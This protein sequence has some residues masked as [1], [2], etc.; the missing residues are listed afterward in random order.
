MTETV[1][2]VNIKYYYSIFGLYFESELELPM[3]NAISKPHSIDAIIQFGE[4]PEHLENPQDAR[5]IYEAKPNHFLMWFNFNPV[6]Y[7]VTNGNTI[8]IHTGGHQDWDFIRLFTLSPAMGA[9]LHQRRVIPLHASGFMIDG[10]AVLFSGQSGAGKSTTAAAFRDKGY[11]LVADDVSVIYNDENNQPI[12]EPG[13]PFVKLWRESFKLL[14]KEVPVN[15]R[16]REQVEK[17]Y[18][19]IDKLVEKALPI[20]RI[21]IL[22]KSSLID[23]PEIKTLSSID[24]VH[25]LRMGTYRYYY[26]IG[27]GGEPEF[28]KIA[29]NLGSQGI[30]KHLTRPMEYPVEDLV[31][32]VEEDLKNG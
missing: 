29:F 9:L 28:F 15:G 20:K 5:V 2:S 22:E 30:V 1:S 24:T 19:P 32:L 18:F 11:T 12:V 7:Y 16:I 14:D 23:T 10:A 6:R 3:L 21:Y 31:K 8:T 13:V 17:Y 27:L 25:H 26:L 4:V